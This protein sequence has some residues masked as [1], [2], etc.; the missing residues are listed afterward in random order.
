MAEIEYIFSLCCWAGPGPN[1]RT[2]LLFFAVFNPLLARA[3]VCRGKSACIYRKTLSIHF[4]VSIHF[5]TGTG[6]DR[7]RVEGNL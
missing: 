6:T 7:V 5:D 3:H 2:N 4:D 1:F